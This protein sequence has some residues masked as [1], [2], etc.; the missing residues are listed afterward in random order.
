MEDGGKESEKES[1]L[2]TEKGVDLAKDQLKAA[3]CEQVGTAV[4][5]YICYRIKIIRDVWNSR[6]DDK[7]VLPNVSLDKTEDTWWNDRIDVEGTDSLMPPETSRIP[8]IEVAP[9]ELP[10]DNHHQPSWSHIVP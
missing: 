3:I 8:P 10:W 5:T 2:D 7:T 9:T 1:E 6:R 4:L